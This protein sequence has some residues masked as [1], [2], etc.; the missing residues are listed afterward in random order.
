MSHAIEIRHLHY[1]AGKSFEIPSLDL[2][3]PAGSI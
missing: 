3:V 1:R 2:T